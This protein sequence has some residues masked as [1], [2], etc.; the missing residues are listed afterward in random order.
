MFNFYFDKD[1]ESF[2]IKYKG[3]K[4]GECFNL[5]RRNDRN[6]NQEVQFHMIKIND[7]KQEIN[8]VLNIIID[9]KIIRAKIKKPLNKDSRYEKYYLIN[10]DWLSKFMEYYNLSDLYNSQIIHKYFDEIIFNTKNINILSNDEVI[11]NA[12]FK[13]EFINIINSFSKNIPKN[14]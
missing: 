8:I 13:N 6:E 12:K 9:L 7:M 11:E 10:N 1:V 4:F 2:E 14:K 3:K 5:N